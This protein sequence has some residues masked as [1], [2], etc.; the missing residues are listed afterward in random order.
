[1]S[2]HCGASNLVHITACDPAVI[3]VP[4]DSLRK[5]MI[6]V[7]CSEKVASGAVF[8]EVAL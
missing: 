4:K 1:M 3:E 5:A 8:V 6:A 2:G 7:D